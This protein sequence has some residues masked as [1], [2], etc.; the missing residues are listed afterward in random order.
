LLAIIIQMLHRLETTYFRYT[1]HVF[2]AMFA[3]NP[4]LLHFPIGEY[5]IRCN[6]GNR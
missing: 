4:K 1:L 3:L 2:R 5:S 6:T